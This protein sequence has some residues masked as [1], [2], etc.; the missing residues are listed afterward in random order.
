MKNS[1]NTTDNSVYAVYTPSNDASTLPRYQYSWCG[2]MTDGEC[3]NLTN[4]L[5]GTLCSLVRFE[6]EEAF[7][8]EMDEMDD[9]H[10]NL[11]AH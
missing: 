11:R 3:E 6:S 9:F 2:R 1:N 7:D 10:Y 8:K 5:K 4:Q